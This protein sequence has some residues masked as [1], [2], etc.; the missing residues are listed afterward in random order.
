M[1]RVA[2]RAKYDEET[3]NLRDGTRQQYESEWTFIPAGGEQEFVHGLGEVPWN[4]SVLRSESATGAVSRQD[5]AE[6]LQIIRATATID[7]GNI[8]SPGQIAVTAT[9]YGAVLGDHVSFSAP[10]DLQQLQGTAYV[11]AA[12]TV[13]V[14]LRNGTGGAIDLASGTWSFIVFK[15][16][17]PV[18]FLNRAG[19]SGSGDRS[20]TVKNTTGRAQYFKVRTM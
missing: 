17:A 20:I 12:D 18:R 1:R 14:M 16:D 10:Y 11:S 15:R 5:S 3:E 9:V 6:T 13:T 4:W 8:V 19:T 7:P 2:A